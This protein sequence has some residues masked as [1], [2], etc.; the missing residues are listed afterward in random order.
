MSSEAWSKALEQGL[1]RG[2][3]AARDMLI[4]ILTDKFGPPDEQIIRRPAADQLALTSWNRRAARAVT[5]P[6]VFG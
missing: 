4:A 1:E 3:Q 2:R 5:L 6:G